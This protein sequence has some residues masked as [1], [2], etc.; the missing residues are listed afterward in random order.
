MQIQA[1]AVEALSR[2]QAGFDRAAQ[3]VSAAA[4]TADT[5]SLSSA[6][7]QLVQARTGVEAAVAAAKT[8]DE[9]AESTLD[10]L[11]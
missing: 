8:A 6:A 11:G 3:R 1:I 7:V 4:A 5:V 10:V 2:A 9:I